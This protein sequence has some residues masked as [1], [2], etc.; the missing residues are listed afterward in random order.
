MNLSAPKQIVFIIAAVMAIL[1]LVV[2]QTGISIP[3]VSGNSY[4]F[5]TGAFG[6][7]AAGTLLRGL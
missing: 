5:M 2:S 6:L 4:W 7:L 3:V 1:S